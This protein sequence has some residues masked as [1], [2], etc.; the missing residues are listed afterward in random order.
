MTDYSELIHQIAY[1]RQS[2]AA[3]SRWTPDELFEVLTQ[4][5]DLDAETL[6]EIASEVGIAFSDT[7]ADVEQYLM[8]LDEADDKEKLK[9]L[10]SARTA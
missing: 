9:R 7:N 5:A 10:L 3:A 8:V 6:R 4:A 1:D 2:V